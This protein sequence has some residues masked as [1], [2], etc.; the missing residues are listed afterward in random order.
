MLGSPGPQAPPSVLAEVRGAWE[1]RVRGGHACGPP[2]TPSRGPWR[3]GQALWPHFKNSLTRLPLATFP[4]TL[5]GLGAS[6]GAVPD[7]S[8]PETMG[9]CGP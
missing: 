5:A 8:A 2:S 7:G 3:R 9:L 6:R 1:K 4:G